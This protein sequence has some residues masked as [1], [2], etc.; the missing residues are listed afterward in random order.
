MFAHRPKRLALALTVLVATG[1]SVADEA[2]AQRPSAEDMQRF[3][4]HVS[5]GAN[6]MERGDYDRAVDELEQAAQIIDHPRLNLQLGDAYASA[7]QCLDAERTYRDIL[8]RDD[9]DDR[10][11]RR[12]DQR[13][14]DL[15]ECPT[16]GE[17]FFQCTPADTEITVDGRHLPCGQWVELEHG[18]Y[19]MT[20]RRDRYESLALRVELEVGDRLEEPVQ[21]IP[22]PHTPTEWT[23]YAGFA[24]VGAGALLLSLGMVQDMRTSSRAEELI[25]AREAGDQARVDDLL[26]S[27]RRSRVTTPLAYGV[28]TAA[29]AGG[30]ALLLFGGSNDDAQGLSLG[31]GPSSVRVSFSW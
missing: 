16:K 18:S 23:T 13:L 31:V 7:G 9:L 12:T 6:A 25:A 20:A 21:L 19:R 24:G 29:A 28:G 22:E 3:E 14:I 11:L 26:S 2:H 8:A 10:T 30:V 15:G 4:G 27:A 17:V 1:L 5:E